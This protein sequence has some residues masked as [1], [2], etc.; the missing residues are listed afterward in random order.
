M[1]SILDP[2]K[3]QSPAI[4]RERWHLREIS[5]PVNDKIQIFVDLIEDYVF[6]ISHNVSDRLDY[7]C[8]IIS[9]RNSIQDLASM[10]I[11]DGRWQSQ[12][13]RMYKGQFIFR[14][15]KYCMV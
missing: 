8:P 11:Y 1:V 7:L 10:S 9:E 14:Y 2:S 4:C 13:P 15:N 5:S 3:L 12:K 6:F